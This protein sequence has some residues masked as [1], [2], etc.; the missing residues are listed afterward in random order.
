MAMRVTEAFRR[1]P[2]PAASFNHQ[3][4]ERVDEAVRALETS[5]GLAEFLRAIADRD[6]SAELLGD[7]LAPIC[8][9]RF[10]DETTEQF[11][12]R[13]MVEAREVIE[14][15]MAELVDEGAL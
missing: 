6:L 15:A 14:A 5:A 8:A 10:D 2:V 7:V 11:S 12:Q 13:A 3:F 4:Q 9:A 1:H